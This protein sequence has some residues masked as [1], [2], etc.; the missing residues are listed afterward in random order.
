[1]TEKQIAFKD[2]ILKR[3]GFNEGNYLTEYYNELFS[4]YSKIFDAQT[5]EDYMERV[6]IN[7]KLT[8]SEKQFFKEK[9]IMTFLKKEYDLKGTASYKEQMGKS[10]YISATDLSNFTFCPVA[11]SISKTFKVEESESAKLGSELHKK[12]RLVNLFWP[13][14]DYLDSSYSK[15]E[16]NKQFFEDIHMSTL[17]FAGHSSEENAEKYFLNDEIGFIGQPD[18]VFENPNGEKFIV[19]EKYKSLKSIENNIIFFD[20]HK[21]QLQSYIYYL[22]QFNAQYGYLVYWIYNEKNHNRVEA[23]K[24]YKVNK[25]ANVIELLD[26]TLKKVQRFNSQ[27]QFDIDKEFLNPKKCA[28]CAYC[29]CCGHKNKRINQ[30]ELPYKRQYHNLYYAEYPEILKNYFL[31]LVELNKTGYLIN[32][33]TT[34]KS[35]ENAR[36]TIVSKIQEHKHDIWQLTN[37]FKDYRKYEIL[38][39]HPYIKNYTLVEFFSDEFSIMQSINE[40]LFKIHIIKM[41]DKRAFEAFGEKNA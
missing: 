19:E 11:Y 39:E 29:Q 20:N 28:N 12:H 6:A 27:K 37:L 21:I 4:R 5:L 10:N 33:F 25:N 40:E 26:S 9:N 7:G 15:D 32:N 17:I 30:V 23:C 31:L 14:E 3:L 36:N 13:I 8:D 38:K 24:V 34:L 16:S 22:N 1:M 18:Y 2:Y 35:A 41:H